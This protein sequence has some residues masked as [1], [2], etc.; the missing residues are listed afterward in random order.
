MFMTFKKLA[1]SGVPY[2]PD[3]EVCFYFTMAHPFF[4]NSAPPPSTYKMLT[5]FME[6]PK[7]SPSANC[8]ALDEDQA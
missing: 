6:S 1:K 8:Q 4:L 7:A 3:M 2:I 5:S